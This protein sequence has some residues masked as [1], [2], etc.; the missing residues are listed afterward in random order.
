L[1][2]RSTRSVTTTEAGERL[3]GVVGPQFEQIESE[4]AALTEFRDKPAGNIRITAPDL[5]AQT[6]LWPVLR[7][8]LPDYPDITV[9][10][11]SSDART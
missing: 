3:L 10:I 7:R 2:N 5:A 4:L 8:L 9:E 1:L 11:V 6:V